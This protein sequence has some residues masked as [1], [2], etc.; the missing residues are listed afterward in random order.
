MLL[1]KV[2]HNHVIF[3]K[4]GRGQGH[5]TPKYFGLKLIAPNGQSYTNFKFQSVPIKH[6]KEIEYSKLCGD[7]TDDVT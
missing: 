3:S 1:R 2:R 7:M 4:R 6:L 5:V